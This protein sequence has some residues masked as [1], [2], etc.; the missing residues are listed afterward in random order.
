MLNAGNNQLESNL[1]TEL[2]VLIP[3]NDS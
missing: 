3:G 2:W 1:L